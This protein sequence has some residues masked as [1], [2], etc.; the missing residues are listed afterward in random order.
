MLWRVFFLPIP[1][2]QDGHN[3]LCKNISVLRAVLSIKAIRLLA[4]TFYVLVAETWDVKCA[5]D[6]DET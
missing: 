1:S 6:R 4:F 3:K 5:T 2:P